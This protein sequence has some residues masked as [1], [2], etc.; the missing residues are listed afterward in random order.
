VLPL[1]GPGLAPAAAAGLPA[2][3]AATAAHAAPGP[4]RRPAELL[5][6]A[7]ELALLDSGMGVRANAGALHMVRLLVECWESHPLLEINDAM[8]VR[9]GWGLGAPRGPAGCCWRRRLLAA[10]GAAAAGC[11]WLLLAPPAA[12]APCAVLVQLG[13][14]HKL[15]LQQA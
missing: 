12:G 9:Q 14:V 1:E 8:E 5:L 6:E 2:R 4:C 13:R 11:C 10:A 15:V 7:G 3:T